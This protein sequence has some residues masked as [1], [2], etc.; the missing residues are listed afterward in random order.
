M[1]WFIKI[2]GLYAPRQ[3][4]ALLAITK[5]KTKTLSISRPLYRFL[6]PCPSTDCAL[7][8]EKPVD[9]P[10]CW[11]AETTKPD[12][13]A[14]LH[15]YIQYTSFFFFSSCIMLFAICI[16]ANAIAYCFKIRMNKKSI[17]N[18]P[19]DL[20]A[21]TFKSTAFSSSY[22]IR[23]DKNLKTKYPQDKWAPHL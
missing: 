3:R 5:P 12:T 20:K 13:L 14:R 10:F 8:N 15:E 6:L 22:K 21:Q 7:P 18:F 4:P 9:S 19:Q 11:A 23:T 17:F 2:F 16:Y 1:R